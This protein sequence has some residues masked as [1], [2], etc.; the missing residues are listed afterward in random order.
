[1]LARDH[2][3]HEVRGHGAVTED[4]VE[5]QDTFGGNRVQRVRNPTQALTLHEAGFR[6][7]G[8]QAG[9]ST[10]FAP[11]SGQTICETTRLRIEPGP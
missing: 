8:V 2:I 9:K 11:D 3:V 5:R 1:M 10:A 6:S 7:S 4:A